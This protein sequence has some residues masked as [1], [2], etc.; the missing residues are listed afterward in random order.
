M[1]HGMSRHPHDTAERCLPRVKGFVVNYS[2]LR[3]LM[4]SS[5]SRSDTGLLLKTKHRAEDIM[6]YINDWDAVIRSPPRF[7]GW[8]LHQKD[9]MLSVRKVWCSVEVPIP[10]GYLLL[11]HV[12]PLGNLCRV[13]PDTHQLV[14]LEEVVVM[15][16]T[17]PR[18][19]L[20]CFRLLKE[21]HR[22]CY[23]FEMLASDIRELCPGG[24]VD[25][26][27][28]R[29]DLITEQDE[30]RGGAPR[31]LSAAHTLLG[32]YPDSRVNV[33]LEELVFAYS[34]KEKFAQFIEKRWVSIRREEIP[35]RKAEE[36]EL[37]VS[38]RK[39]RSRLLIPLPN[40]E[41][42]QAG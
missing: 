31:A 12:L 6:K 11:R 38:R 10:V 32:R 14:E 41:E 30:L 35:K 3:T 2:R 13:D 8:C 7:R 27:E 15:D 21:Y 28:G 17:S 37:Q 29:T 39:R 5:D 24:E 16:V 40:G 19:A 25:I 33:G 22:C 1:R 36:D 26:G 42:C 34:D 9:L 23:S 18:K 4:L 20:W